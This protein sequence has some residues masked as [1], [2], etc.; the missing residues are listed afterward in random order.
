V[1][2]FLDLGAQPAPQAALVSRCN[3]FIRIEFVAGT[4]RR[5]GFKLSLADQIWDKFSVTQLVITYFAAVQS[6]AQGASYTGTFTSGQ[7]R[8]LCNVA[9]PEPH[10]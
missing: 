9:L 10:A 7:Y 4:E 8:K 6:G 1:A 2:A 5:L 3:N